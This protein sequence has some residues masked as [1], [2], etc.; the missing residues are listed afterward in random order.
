MNVLVCNHKDNNYPKCFRDIS[1]YPHNIYY[2]GD[3]SLLN[4]T[5]KVAVIGTR[6]ISL[7]GALVTDNLTSV[8]LQKDFVILN[9]MALGCDTIALK[10]VVKEGKKAI[11][12]LPCG[13]DNIQPKSNIALMEEIISLG[14]L[15]LSEYP[16]GTVLSKYMYVQRDR[17]QAAIADIVFVI[18]CKEK[19]GTMHTVD[20]ALKYMKPVA[21]FQD[22]FE[23]NANGNQYL[24]NSKKAYPIHDTPS[25]NLFLMNNMFQQLSFV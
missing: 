1:N 12:V 24:I 6:D 23:K 18:E 17:L 22:L 16:N 3:L 20:F 21:C 11:V 14:G 19:S 25:L 2:V 4:N 10:T 8:L 7:R 13:F 15:V 9:G 5:K